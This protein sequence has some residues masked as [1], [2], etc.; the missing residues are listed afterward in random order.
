LNSEEKIKIKTNFLEVIPKFLKNVKGKAFSRKEISHALSVRKSDYYLF[1][2]ALNELSKSKKIIR[3]KGGKYVVGASLR[4]TQGIIQITR[5]GFAFVT[6]ERT[7]EDIFVSQQNLN[8]ALDGDMIEV[9]LFAVSRGKSKEGQVSKIIS[10]ANN[11]FVGTYHKSEYYGFVVPDNPKIYRDFLVTDSDT[12]NAKEGQKVVVELKKWEALQLNPEGRIT[13]I[14][15][16]PDEPGVDI[17]SVVKGFGL[18]LKFSSK[19]ENEASKIQ[20]R[21]S[22]EEMNKRLDLRDKVVFT[23]DPEEAKDFDDAVS[24]DL[25]KNGNY[26]LGVHIADV[27]HFVTSNSLIDKEAIE[28]GT[29]IYLVDRVIPMLPEHLSNELCS[30]QPYQDRFTFSCIMEISAEGEV[31]H[32]EIKKSIINSKRRFSYYEVQEIIDNTKSNGQH[33]ELIKQMHRLSRILRQ[34]RFKQGSIDFDT[35][36]VKFKLDERG[37]P[38]EIIPV[39]R[40]QSM[41]MIEEFMLL[42]NKTVTKHV[43]KMQIKGRSYPFIFRV[44]EK[45]DSE[46]L[47]KFQMVLKAL[48]YQIKL[49]KTVTPAD[50]QAVMDRI[51]G[52]KDEI[53][54]KE[55]ALRTMM[56]ASYSP[57]NIG[58]FGLAF[59]DYTHFTSPIRRY[60]DLMVH[61]L[62]KEYEKPINYKRQKG[63]KKVLQKICELASQKERT[64]LDAERQ[65]I[66][67]KQVEWISQHL[68]NVFE[69]IISGVASFGIFVET[70]PYLIEGM[71]SVTNLMDDYYIYEEK[72]YSM[73]GRDSGQSFRLGDPVRVRVV[74][75]D[76]EQN[77][78][79]FVLV[80]NGDQENENLTEEGR[81]QSGTA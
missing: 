61:R 29:S 20:M 69:G 81:F 16:F 64:A 68:G 5:K 17:S 21:L 28:R 50:F 56:K 54:V 78:V 42:A 7:G 19:V 55:V 79:D 10:R 62:L 9:Q 58:H 3:T 72:T 22:Q 8:T 37:F 46:K 18:P 2:E 74:K 24:L 45:P 30:L 35:P 73:I 6:D 48:G 52:S 77:R 43:I 60:P 51:K 63:L 11:E 53:L 34:N 40:L 32:Y 80:K 49:T 76:R 66:K 33:S 44:H 65:S 14:I 75:V 13:E 1:R 47:Q 4:I 41:E 23:I 71:V 59:D 67:V 27:S 38:T 57:K 26:Q 70:I 36:E 12:I 25:L 39:R 31:K 15:G